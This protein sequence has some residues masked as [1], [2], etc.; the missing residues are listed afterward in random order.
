MIEA[1]WT[2]AAEADVQQLYEQLELREEGSGDRFYHEVLSS[3]RLLECFPE[4]GPVVFSDR[5]RRMLVVNHHY[6]LYYVS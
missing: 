3:V 1:V 6:G 5:V 4:M 2:L